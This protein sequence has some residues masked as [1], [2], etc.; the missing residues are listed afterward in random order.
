M[1]DPFYIVS[2]IYQLSNFYAHNHE[3]SKGIKI[4]NEGIAIAGQYNLRSKLNILYIAL[5]ENYQSDGDYRMYSNV[6]NKIIAL[7]DSTYTKNS[8]DALSHDIQTKYEVQKKQNIIISQQLDLTKKNTLFF[9]TLVLLA[10]TVLV[11]YVVF[12]SRKKN[13]QLKLREIV[14]EQK[15]QT[16]DAVMQAEENERKRIAG[17]LHDSVAQKMVVAKLN[18]EAFEGYLP[19]LNTEQR[20]VFNNIFSLV[21]E[22][23]TEV[24]N[25]S[26][27][28]MPQA[29][30]QS[31]LADAVKNFIDKIENKNLHILFNVEVRSCQAWIKIQK[32]MIYRVIQECLQ[33]IIKHAQANKVDIA[34]IAENGEIDVTIEDN[35]IGFDPSSAEHAGGMGLKNI[36]S[37][38]DFLN[39]Q[40][41]INSKPG[42]GSVVA[43][44][45]PT[46]H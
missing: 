37:R 43:F 5:S 31:G 23:C 44:F 7:K 41:D 4:A 3:P 20:H 9:G 18:L 29:F 12:R 6:L 2:D 8:A 46:R 15:K 16:M 21:D 24:R 40:L 42:M 35:G 17:E 14:V 38:I 39:G 28:M 13:Q 10:S 30:F 27:S 34:V 1:A 45:I 22:S 25:L 33:N 19:A 11:F 26:H 36:R 32:M